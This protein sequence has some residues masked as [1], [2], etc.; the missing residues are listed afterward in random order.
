[1]EGVAR[2]HSSLAYNERQW[3]QNHQL[4]CP[5]C[6]PWRGAG[7][8]RVRGTRK[9]TASRKLRVGRDR[10]SASWKEKHRPG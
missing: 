9:P 3:L 4:F 5:T 8:P 1:M 7:S 10:P 6:R 2:M